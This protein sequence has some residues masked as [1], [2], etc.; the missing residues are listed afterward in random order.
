MDRFLSKIL[1]RSGGYFQSENLF[2]HELW[3]QRLINIGFRVL[4]VEKLPYHDV[5]DIR[6]CGSLSAQ[7]YLLVSKPVPKK[8]IG[9]P[10]LVPKQ[11]RS[12]IRQIGQDLGCPIKRDCMTV[13]RSGAYFRASFIWPLGKPGRLLK[14]EKKAEAFSFLIQPW[15]RRNRN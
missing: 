7:T 14:Q 5:W 13:V 10:D 3:K 11:L 8:L 6:V 2:F 4:Y 15:L 1:R 12:E 9:I